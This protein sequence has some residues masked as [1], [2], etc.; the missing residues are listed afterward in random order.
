MLLTFKSYMMMM[1]LTEVPV[2]T[3]Q[4]SPFRNDGITE[5]LSLH[6]QS[7][8]S[9]AVTFARENA[10][11]FAGAGTNAVVAFLYRVVGQN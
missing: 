11:F 5:T 4:R 10:G 9:D 8:V 2:L 7:S 3:I 6:E 1:V